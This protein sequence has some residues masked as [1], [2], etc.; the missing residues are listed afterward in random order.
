MIFKPEL[1]E[2]ILAGE[3][4]MTRRPVKRVLTADEDGNEWTNVAICRYRVGYTYAVQPGWGQKGVARIKVTSV[5]RERWQD[6]SPEDAVAE[7]FGPWNPEREARRVPVDR[8]AD[9]VRGLH[10]DVNPAS[11]CWVIEFKPVPAQSPEAGNQG[12]AG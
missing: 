10:P 6:I 5:R 7:G 11:E 9:Y 12:E 3:K 1:V 4:T 8:F 2:K